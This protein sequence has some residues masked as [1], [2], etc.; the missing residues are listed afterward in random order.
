KESFLF[1]YGGLQ[2][3]TGPK[4]IEVLRQNIPEL[5]KIAS[6]VRKRKPIGIAAFKPPNSHP[7]EEA[8]I[9]DYV[10]MLGLPLVPSHKF[11]ESS[12][13]AFFSVHS[14][15]ENGFVDKLN[16][17]I[18]NG[19]TVLITDGLAKRIGNKINLNLPNVVLLK[20]NGAPKS[21]LQL[22]QQQIN[23]LQAK[24]LKPFK[25][26]FKSGNKVGFYLYSDGSYVI[27]N[28]NN[29]PVDV[30]LN[31]KILKIDSRGWIYEWK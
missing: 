23:E 19:K 11:T 1:C 6:E 31:G 13:T 14:L 24:V 2:G 25:V 20:V 21:L 30:E 5:L 18:Q 4:N 22:S 28:F 3:S 16:R 9:F 10:G 15:K 7:E 29:E 8:Y 12:P 27:E 26:N 17:Y